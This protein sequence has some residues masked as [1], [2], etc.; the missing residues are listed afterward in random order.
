MLLS[1]AGE[2]AALRR[3]LLLVEPA[4]ADP[5]AVSVLKVEGAVQQDTTREKAGVALLIMPS[6]LQNKPPPN[7]PINECY[8]LS[9]SKGCRAFLAACR[10]DPGVAER[11]FQS[12]CIHLLSDVVAQGPSMLLLD[13]SALTTNGARRSGFR[14]DPYPTSHEHDRSGLIFG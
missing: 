11:R 10:R 14:A 2:A 13:L 7:L 1:T 5:L 12:N 6:L 4:A 8:I 9:H 3:L